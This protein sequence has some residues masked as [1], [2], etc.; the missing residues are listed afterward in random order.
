MDGENPGN[1]ARRFPSYFG[2]RA[3]AFAGYLHEYLLLISAMNA[4]Q[5]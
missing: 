5:P 1:P 4:P 2:I 3:G